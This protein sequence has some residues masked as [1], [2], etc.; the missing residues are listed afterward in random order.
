[1][2]ALNLGPCERVLPERSPCSSPCPSSLQ[3][4]RAMAPG[5]GPRRRASSRIRSTRARLTRGRAR[6]RSRACA[7]HTRRADERP[8]LVSRWKLSF[9]S[10][11][12]FLS[13]SWQAGDAPRQDAQPG[14]FRAAGFL[15]LVRAIQ[16]KAL[17]TGE[18]KRC[19]CV[20]ARKKC[21]TCTWE[22]PRRRANTG[23]ARGPTGARGAAPRQD[24]LEWA[25]DVDE[26]R[27]AVP[28]LAGRGVKDRGRGWCRGER[29]VKHAASCLVSPPADRRPFRPRRRRRERWR[30]PRPLPP[31]GAVRPS[32]QRRSSWDP[33]CP[34]DRRR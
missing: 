19:E 6:R 13:R 33:P 11:D 7:A 30:S 12:T 14:R 9:P 5:A 25:P 24:S 29:R 26:G 1:M 18:S 17:E 16:S 32:R 22:L 28:G 23:G 8:R 4:S 20:A 15:R 3:F 2:A 10:R 27:L 31:L 34:G 21:G